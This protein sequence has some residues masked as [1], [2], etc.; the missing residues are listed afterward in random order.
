MSKV[1][2][3]TYVCLNIIQITENNINPLLTM[4]TPFLLICRTT[5]TPIPI[6]AELPQ[7]NTFQ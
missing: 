6:A 5:S 1:S 4:I 3:C 7:I 2:N